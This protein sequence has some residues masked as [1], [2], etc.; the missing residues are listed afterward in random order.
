V[1][2]GGWLCVFVSQLLCGVWDVGMDWIKYRLQ[3]SLCVIFTRLEHVL[4][5]SF[6]DLFMGVWLVSTRVNDACK[7]ISSR[8]RFLWLNS[9]VS[10]A[11]LDESFD[12]GVPKF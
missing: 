1:E 10:S 9:A 5:R 8:W 12:R 7:S 3:S 11:G 2:R 6:G 4:I